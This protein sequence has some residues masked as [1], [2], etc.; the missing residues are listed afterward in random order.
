[1]RGCLA[2]GQKKEAKRGRFA[3]IEHM[4]VSFLMEDFQRR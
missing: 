2:G 3:Y 4:A 1:M